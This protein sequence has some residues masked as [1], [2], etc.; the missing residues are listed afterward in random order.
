MKLYISTPAANGLLYINYVGSL[1]S[2]ANRALA[3]GLIE[4]FR[5]DM[6]GKESLIHRG[7]DR[8]AMNFLDSEYDKLLTIDADIS[9]TYEDFKRII[10]SPH[11]ITGGMYPIKTF[12][13]VANFNPLPDQ[14]TEF[15]QSERGYDYDAYQ[16]F[17]HKY[18]DPDGYAEVRH[19]PTGFM[20]VTRKVFCD[21][22]HTVETY[23][24]VTPASGQR[25][26]YFHF[27]PSGV[28]SQTLRSEDWSFCEIAR[29]H[30]FKVMLDTKI[31]LGHTGYHEFRL[32]Q[33]FAQIKT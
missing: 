20:C 1:I 14:G 28:K 23:F 2:S 4:D 25:R 10:T 13:V 16:K 19:I 33:M 11:D 26:G 6:D 9:F 22:S 31:S 5:L 17:V 32:G 8:A 18:A 15:W 12:P 3:E 30:G 29:E 21:L 27:Y 24:S 7:R